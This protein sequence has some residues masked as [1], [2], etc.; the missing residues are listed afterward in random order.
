MSEKASLRNLYLHKRNVLTHA[1]QEQLNN[2][3]SDKLIILLG[4]LSFSSL[5]TFLPQT[6]KKEIDTQRIISRIR[7]DFKEAKI[8]A[9][10]VTPGTR[11]MEHYFITPDTRLVLNRWLIPEPDPVSSESADVAQIDIVLIP[12]LAFDELGFRVGYGGG[13]Y[14]RFLAECKPSTVKI[15]VSFFD[16]IPRIDDIDPFD[17]P[18]DFCITPHQIFGWKH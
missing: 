13:Y 2:Q 15:G 6:G 9:P 3:I 8:I 1:E 16:P 10:R 11:H 18:M 7:Q 5:H 12:L 4:T 17:I 14:D